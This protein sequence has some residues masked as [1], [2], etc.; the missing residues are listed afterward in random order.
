MLSCILAATLGKER[1][2]WS[3]GFIT[4]Y[5]LELKQIGDTN[6]QAI[7]CINSQINQYKVVVQG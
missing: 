6:N 5:L 3:F 1:D 4:L 2:S 7:Y